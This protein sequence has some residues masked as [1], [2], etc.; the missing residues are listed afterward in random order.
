M[1]SPEMPYQLSPDLPDLN[2][3]V[4]LYSLDGFVDAGS[5]GRLLRE[6]ILATLEHQVIATFDVDE[7]IDYRA[8][9]PLM[10][11]DK[12]RWEDYQAPEL[13]LH[14]VRDGTGEPFLLL[15]GPEPDRSWEAFVTSVISV[16]ER[17]DVRLATS[18]QGIPMAAPHTRPLGT[19]MHATRPELLTGRRSWFGRVQIPGSAAA[20]LE[21]R[22]GQAGRDAIGFAVHVP[23]YLAQ[24]A[25]PAAAIKALEAVTAAT[26]LMIPG[27]QLR[28]ASDKADA[29]IN[30]QVA[31]SE[32]IAD[33]IRGL[34]Q[35]Y[36]AFMDAQARE[37]LQAAAENMPTGE[38]LAAQFERFLSEQNGRGD[39]TQ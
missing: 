28:E 2:R 38:E 7:F 25:Y 10:T 27:P 12:D 30:E 8:R 16:A 17:L 35:Q 6:H 5:A 39:G 1:P 14:L 24:A 9:R 18:F 36:D 31:G 4:L 22:L 26:G 19:T 15:A 29:E 20:L 21:L 3:P 32:E 34:E 37:D 11:Y 33:V 13:A 23:H